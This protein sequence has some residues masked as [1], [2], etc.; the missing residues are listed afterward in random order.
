MKMILGFFFLAPLTLAE[1]ADIATI[2]GIPLAALVLI[3]TAYQIHQN[4]K[5]S[6]GQFWLELE[7]MFTQHDE[8]HIK[9][10]PGGEWT[11]NNTGPKSVEEWAKVEDYMGLFEHCEIMLRK[12]LIDWETFGLI[13]SYRLHNIAANKIIVSVKLRQ[14]RKS[15][16]AFIRLLNRLK[17]QIPE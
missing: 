2:A 14:E 6:R 11:S 10:R 12:R 4:T 5:I 8:V 17:I 1:W 13:F 9:L 16:Q 3:Y 7:K 15:W